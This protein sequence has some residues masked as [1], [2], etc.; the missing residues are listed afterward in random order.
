MKTAETLET[1][2]TFVRHGCEVIVASAQRMRRAARRPAKRYESQ[3]YESLH[4]FPSYALSSSRTKR[5]Y[6]P[7]SRYLHPRAS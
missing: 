7:K 5:R 3:R 2:L 4:L 1:V 6:K